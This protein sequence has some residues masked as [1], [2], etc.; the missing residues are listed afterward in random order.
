MRRRI[1]AV[2]EVRA[3]P[4][5]PGIVRVT[6]LTA[7]AVTVLGLGVTATPA[8]AE[9][10][11]VT[12]WPLV[13]APAGNEVRGVATDSSGS[14]YVADYDAAEIQKFT[15]HGTF[16]AKWGSHGSAN[17]QF[18]GAAD[19]A[20]GAGGSVYV[21]DFENFSERNNRVQRF[22][23]NGTFLTKW[24][25]RGGADGE[26]EG[27]VGLATDPA[28]NVYV[29][30]RGNER[31]Q[32]FD[33]NGAFITEWEVGGADPSDDV[34]RS[35]NDVTTDSAGN[36]YVAD[37]AGNGRIWKYTSDGTLIAD[38]APHG[39]ASPELP[40]FKI[41]TL[42]SSA[43]DVW[44]AVWAPEY[45]HVGGGGGVVP[46]FAR[47]QQFTDSGGFVR[48]FGCAGSGQDNFAGPWGVATDSAGD[49]YVGDRDR[50]Q[51]LGDPGTQ[52]DCS[53]AFDATAKKRQKLKKMRVSASCPQEAC[54]LTLRG[55]ARVRSK[56]ARLRPKETSLASGETTRIRLRVID[57]K[58]KRKLKRALKRRRFKPT[59]VSV[60]LQANDDD[61]LTAEKVV[62][63]R[64]KRKR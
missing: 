28:G 61:G 34:Y 6:L 48:D 5:R 58:R 54:E 25:S 8:R 44:V 20:V 49:V 19:V 9:F 59:K 33:P 60:E 42:A 27:P 47:L 31:I 18:A 38:W 46:P 1:N 39:T 21:A 29:A 64:L 11:F 62:T 10:G 15:S 56:G 23:S 12:S 40:P 24:G 55:R 30:D 3:M 36:V 35:P 22:T 7:V 32:K 50:V 45:I 14:V 13:P 57:R 16:I 2:R 51:K 63:F 52:A 17:G 53:F 43:E 41:V 26:F 37:S 4:R